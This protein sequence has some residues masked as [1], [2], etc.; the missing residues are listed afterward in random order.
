MIRA[1]LLILACVMVDPAWA[2]TYYV[3]KTGS[4]ANS[5][6]VDAPFLTIKKG[7]QMAAPCDTI[8]VKSGTYT[9]ADQSPS[10]TDIALYISAGQGIG[11][12][13]SACPI[14][15]K[16][17]V[18]LGAIIKIPSVNAGS[19]AIN[20]SQP[21][22]IIEGFDI[23]GTG[24]S[25]N[26]GANASQAGITVGANNTIVR[27][28][29]IWDVA[30]AMCNDTAFGQSGMLILNNIQN[31]LIEYNTF[32]KIGRRR[33]NESGCGFDKYHHDHG[34]YEAG[35]DNTT[36]RHNVFYDVDRG[37]PIT[38]YANGTTHDN[39]TF[40]HNTVDQGSPDARIGGT[41]TL[42]NVMTNITIK[43]N[44]FRNPAYGYAVEWCPGSTTTNVVI[45]NNISNTGTNQLVNPSSRPGT[46]NTASG[47][48]LNATLG[49]K[50]TTAGS[51]DFRLTSSSAAINAGAS[52]G[53]ASCGSA[54]DIGAFE[55]CPIL[56]A[57]INGQSLDMTFG[58]TILPIQYVSGVVSVGCTGTGCGTPVNSNLTVISSPGNVV[59]ATITGITGTN[60][61]AGQTWT[62]TLN[63]AVLTD[64]S[65]VGGTLSQDVLS[66][67]TFAVTNACSGSPPPPP[68]GPNI[69]YE[70][71]ENTG[72]SLTNTGS[73]GAGLNGTLTGGGTWG[74]GLTGSGVVLTAQSGQYV[75][76]PY[77][78]A[79]DP[80]TQSLTI[81]FWVNVDPAN[82][83]LSRSYFGSALGTNQRFYITTLDS[84]WRLGI[85][86]SNDGIVS[87]LPVTSGMTHVCVKADSAT[88]QATLYINGVAST[89]A[90]AKKSYT[91]FALASNFELGRIGGIAS[92]AGGTFDKLYI[93]PSAED[94]NAIY[95][96]QL[97]VTSTVGTFTLRTHRWEGAYLAVGGGVDVR[98]SNGA[99]ALITEGGTIAL[100][101]QIECDNVAACDA[102]PFPL[103]YA[104]D[105]GAYTNT[106][107][108]IATSN[109]VRYYG[110]SVDPQLNRFSAVGP[111]SGAL[112]H[113]NGVTSSLS[114]HV[115]QN[116]SL[117]QNSSLTIRYLITF[118][119]GSSGHVYT[120]RPVRTNGIPLNTIIVTPSITV[121]PMRA[122]GGS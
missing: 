42:C 31:T 43:N 76:I 73:G 93:Y 68:A 44:I 47:N 37:Y 66:F 77:G 89:S 52:L 45:S 16:S 120:F 6:A 102:T 88:D 112:S 9:A 62:V 71:D 58:T 109:A 41:L 54:P 28:N 4:D 15:L 116:Y 119:K 117:A 104:V 2:A 83:A 11:A 82:V 65:K 26:T 100:H 63:T 14:T 80:S 25:Q 108:D 10:R 81:S 96:A 33:F 86:A 30:R 114:S 75:A 36:V 8:I 20:V 1:A 101:V 91:S 51:E 105:G 78:N 121:I 122:N 19:A 7:A 22:W 56:S 95:T 21:Y 92:G 106:L 59:R 27:R 103:S 53:N 39:I 3:A 57:S 70:M 97:P 12:G 94:C 87:D 38:I 79:I 40:V 24:V 118:T 64:S 49:L 67:T 34:I 99:S 111:L 113:T 61:A 48:I 50:N 69:I 55:T 46:G 17:E 5:G 35:G 90:G 29:H 107:D 13:T 72:T 85:Q 115:L 98:T 60:C 23:N 32:N 110:S 84:T 74:T 18:P